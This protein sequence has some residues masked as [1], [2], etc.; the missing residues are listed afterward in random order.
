VIT[1]TAANVGRIAQ[2]VRQL[3]S[4]Q[5]QQHVVLP[6]QHAQ[7]ADVAPVLEAAMGKRSADTAIQVLADTRTNRLLFVGPP[8]VRQRLLDMA[9]SLDV[10]ATAILDNARVIRLRHS[11]ARQLAEVLDS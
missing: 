2:V 9:R 11:D 6:L 4:G 8:E 5:S 1:D 10:P 3:D 7:A